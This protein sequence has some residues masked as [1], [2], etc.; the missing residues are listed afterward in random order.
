MNKLV[1][2]LPDNIV[3]ERHEVS[4]K[5]VLFYLTDEQAGKAM[6]VLSEHPVEPSSDVVERV[7][8]AI[9]EADPI[10]NI[11]KPNAEYF[12]HVDVVAKA[13]IKAMKGES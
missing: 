5:W 12:K 4:G 10:Y 2:A 1:E 7:A 13:A 8:R 3:A 9:Y 6:R 11:A